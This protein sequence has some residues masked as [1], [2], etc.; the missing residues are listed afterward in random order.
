MLLFL[1]LSHTSNVTGLVKK[2]N[3]KS[4][5]LKSLAIDYKLNKTHLF[6]SYIKLLMLLQA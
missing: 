6:V 2:R 3:E 5:A 4:E 1:L